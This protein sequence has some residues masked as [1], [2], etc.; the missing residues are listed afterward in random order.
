MKMKKFLTICLA[1]AMV[2]SLLS[3]TAFAETR[4]KIGKIQLNVRADFKIGDSGG[5]ADVTTTTEH[6][7]VDDVEVVNDDTDN[8]SRTNTPLLK[9]WLSTDEDDYYFSGTSSSNFKLKLSGSSYDGI[10]FKQAD[11]SEKNSVMTVTARLTYGKYETVSPAPGNVTWDQSNNG[12]GNW[13]DPGN[14]KYYQ[15][16]LLRDG[17]TEGSAFSSYETS[18]NFAGRITQAGTYRFRVRA[19]DASTNDK[20]DWVT[21]GALS[22]SADQ[23]NQ[24]VSSSGSWQMA[25]DNVRKWWRFND[26]SWPSSQWMLIS[27]SWYYFDAAG[28][29]CTGWQQIGGSY[30]YLDPSTGAM[31]AN[32]RTPDGYWVNQDGV[33]IPGS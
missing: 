27:G 24:L 22:V 21:S 33:W 12:V 4:K 17:N 7:Y 5:N 15:L 19:V 10:K 23:A 31:W 3:A 14:A 8:W 32:Q 6:V 26:G 29:M 13:S 11:K 1:A 30:Y 9:I 16:Q 2:S 25:A 18:Y 28:Y 20:S